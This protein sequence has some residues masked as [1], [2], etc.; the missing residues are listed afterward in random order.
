MELDVR[1]GGRAH[2]D[3]F[4]AA[5]RDDAVYSAKVRMR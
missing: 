4:Q 1:D 2:V 3:A 5:I